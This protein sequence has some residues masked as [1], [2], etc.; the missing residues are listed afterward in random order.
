MLNNA[1]P[2]NSV[3]VKNDN[4]YSE[5]TDL[6]VCAKS[7]EMH[8]VTKC[9]CQS[10]WNYAT[11]SPFI[12]HSLRSTG[13]STVRTCVSYANA[14]I[15]SWRGM[16]EINYGFCYFG[17]WAFFWHASTTPWLSECG[18]HYALDWQSSEREW[19]TSWWSYTPLLYPPQ[20]SVTMVLLGRTWVAIYVQVLVHRVGECVQASIFLL[21]VP[22]YRMSSTLVSISMVT[23]PC[24]R[25]FSE[26][27]RAV[28]LLSTS[29][30]R[31]VDWYQRPH[32]RCWL[33][34]L[35]TNGWTTGIAHWSA[36]LPT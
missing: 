32:S 3:L 21:L 16:W 7:H 31:S 20:A 14:A 2:L 29:Y 23:F 15:G 34:P 8:K 33:S 28:S 26:R 6:N 22:R 19:T 10:D 36:F 27:L 13:L 25:T 35:S 30:I 9:Q 4:F 17:I 5:N 11:I 18:Y 1:C 24:G 12:W